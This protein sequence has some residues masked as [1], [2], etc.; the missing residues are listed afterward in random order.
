MGAMLA[1]PE[2]TRETAP[3]TRLAAWLPR[4]RNVP[5]YRDALRAG[6][7][8]RL[9]IIGKSELRQNFP[10]NF[11]PPGQNLDALLQYK[12]VEIEYSSGTSEDRTAVLFGRGWWDAQEARLLSLNPLGAGVLEEFPAARRIT[13]VPPVCNGLVCFSNWNF[14]SARTVGR[15]LYVNQARIP[16][17]LPE[18]ELA[19]MA[20]ETADWAPQFLDVDPVQGAWF[21]LYCERQG[22]RFPSLKFIL[23]SYEFVSVV[24]RRVLERVFGVPVFNLYG[25][26][27]TGHLL[28]END[29]GEMKPCP[30]AVYYEIIAP[31]ERGVGDLVVT[32][33]TNDIMP[34]LRYRLGDLMAVG[35]PSE[36]ADYVVH[37]RSRDALCRRDGRRVTTWEVDQCL[38]GVGGV[39]HYQLRQTGDN[40][41][42]FQYVADGGGPWAE[43]LDLVKGRLEEL[44]QPTAAPDFE[45]VAMLPPTPSGK[46][47][48]TCRV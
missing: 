35:E 25:S 8:S 1:T 44:L 47:R 11:L 36:G 9:P 46:F 26:T 43:D 23:C 29:R 48:L 30:E 38:V 21:A 32:T 33:L 27:E 18:A 19:R 4:W 24:H 28:M 13:I 16:F 39:V 2:I 37:G 22:L 12:E 20:R 3:W 15:T 6:G 5:L 41:L 7:F 14:L 10:G 31:D 40:R 17:L 45:R 34:L 42:A